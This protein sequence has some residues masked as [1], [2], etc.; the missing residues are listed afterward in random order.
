MV[1]NKTKIEELVEAK[2]LIEDLRLGMYVSRLDRPWTETHFVLQGFRIDSMQDV[3]QLSKYCKFVYIDQK[4]SSVLA[5]S[6][7]P[8]KPL[9][10]SSDLWK[11]EYSLE[12]YS[13]TQ[14]FNTEISN[15]ENISTDILSELE[16]F[17]RNIKNPSSADIESLSDLITEMVES[18]IR[19]PDALV[20]LSQVKQGHKEIYLHGLRLATWAS[21][22]GRQLGFNRYTLSQLNNCLLL[23]CLGKSQLTPQA[24]EQ[25]QPA[26]APKVFQNHLDSTLY[27]LVKINQNTSTI[28]TLV[29][30]Y[31]ERA[32]GSGYPAGKTINEIP[33]LSQVA[34]LVETFDLAIHPFCFSKAV[35]PATAIAQL[36]RYRGSLFNPSLVEAFVAA[37]GIYPTGTLVELSDGRVG[38]VISQN[39]QR[40]L[41]A[42]VLL[43]SNPQKKLVKTHS[44]IH[45]GTAKAIDKKGNPLSIKRGLPATSVK[46]EILLRAHE[47]LFEQES[48]MW[49]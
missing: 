38:I 14:P 34:G 10:N 18:V 9:Q 48:R 43:L 32:D 27:Q 29:E 24:L 33:F 11:Q 2:V 16:H 19:N 46:K 12:R 25:Y 41:R 4:K 36:N 31:C 35:P 15:A 49:E 26:R 3:Q 6:K 45:L 42:S 28:Y 8:S 1:N 30:N 40:R 17:S 37:V 39:H 23:T 44:I 20:W 13:I 47:H 5:Q 22:F 7:T 21:L